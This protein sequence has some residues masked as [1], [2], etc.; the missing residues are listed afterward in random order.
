MYSATGPRANRLS[1]QPFERRKRS[2]A[3]IFL[4]HSRHYA[5][6][7]QVAN[8]GYRHAGDRHCARQS[9]ADVDAG[10]HI[11]GVG[12]EFANRLSQPAFV[13]H[14]VGFGGVP[15]VHSAEV[16]AVGVRIAD[17]LNNRH[18][19]F[20]VQALEGRRVA[21]NRQVVVDGQHILLAQHDFLA[22]VVVVRVVVR[23][24]GVH[25]VVAAGEL[26]DY[27]SLLL[28]FGAHS[29][30]HLVFRVSE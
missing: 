15:D 25:K 3:Q 12:V 11:I 26:H 1:V 17:A 18:P 9:H 10:K 19:A 27:Q 13:A 23:H 4:L 7:F 30:P 20:V 22:G 8:G 24:D 29:I 28:A 16:G 6:A 21:V 5:V 14:A 2:V